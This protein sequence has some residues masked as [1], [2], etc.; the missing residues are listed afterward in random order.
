MVSWYCFLSH[1]K[2]CATAVHWTR[3][4]GNLAA[5]TLSLSAVGVRAAGSVLKGPRIS[6]PSSDS[7]HLIS[8]LVPP[9][10]GGAE[11]LSQDGAAD[12]SPARRTG[13]WVRC[14]GWGERQA[15]S[16]GPSG[17]G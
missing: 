7:Y 2:H 3:L 1:E 5:V 17:D 14:N 16:A 11:D 9:S 10:T 8:E 6:R 4:M 13:Q 15:V 12:L